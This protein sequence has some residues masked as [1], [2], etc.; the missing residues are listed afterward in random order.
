M[1][2]KDFTIITPER[3]WHFVAE[4]AE[5]GDATVCLHCLAICAKYLHLCV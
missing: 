2:G 5:V 4:S 1:N 3:N